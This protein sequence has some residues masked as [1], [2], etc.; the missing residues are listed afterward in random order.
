MDN[1]YQVENL[2]I[3]CGFE[4]I[5]DSTGTAADAYLQTFRQEK[6]KRGQKCAELNTRPIDSVTRKE[7]RIDTLVGPVAYGHLSFLK[8]IDHEFERQMSQ[9]PTGDYDDGPDALQGAIRSVLRPSPPKKKEYR[10]V[11]G[12]TLATEGKPR[13]NRLKL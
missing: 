12:F 6:D 10:P 5:I 3:T 2:K 4:R 11:D 13:G 1:L 8:D 9:Y 7:T